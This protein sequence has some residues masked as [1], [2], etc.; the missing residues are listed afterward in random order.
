L[1]F[2][3]KRRLPDFR[4]G[5]RAVIADKDQPPKWQPASLSEVSDAFVQSLFEP[6]SQGDLMLADYWM[7]PLHG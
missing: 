1:A 6:L 5:I 4:E 7:P 2:R 3:Q